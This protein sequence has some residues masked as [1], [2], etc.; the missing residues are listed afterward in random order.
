MT[1][2]HDDSA[3][4]MTRSARDAAF[5]A[6]MRERYIA[7]GEHVSTQVRWR[8]RPGVPRPASAGSARQRGWHPGGV[9]AGVAAAVF[10]VALGIGLYSPQVQ[11]PG[12]AALASQ[13]GGIDNS[14]PIEPLDQD[15]DFYAWLDSDD[16]SS[17]AMNTGARQ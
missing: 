4:D 10:A 14:N 7:A 17:L 16:V 1:N 12:T 13:Q 5:D 15:P 3:T 6:A 11:S 2:M 9:F 8:A